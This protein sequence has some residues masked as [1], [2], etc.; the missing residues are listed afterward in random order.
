MSLVISFQTALEA[1]GVEFIP[2]DETKGPGVRLKHT[3]R[4]KAQESREA[5]G[6]VLRLSRGWNRKRTCSLTGHLGCAILNVGKS[7]GA[8]RSR[9]KATKHCCETVAGQAGQARP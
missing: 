2:A 3:S 9:A 7:Q 4:A 8:P 1:A 5:R 6:L